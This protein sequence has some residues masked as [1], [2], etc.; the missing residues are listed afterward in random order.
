MIRRARWRAVSWPTCFSA[1][2]HL[3][4][5]PDCDIEGVDSREAKLLALPIDPFEHPATRRSSTHPDGL[6]PRAESPARRAI[7]RRLVRGQ[8]RPHAQ[9]LLT[10]LAVRRVRAHHTRPEARSSAPATHTQAHVCTVRARISQVTTRSPS[11]P[12]RSSPTSDGPR[13]MSPERPAA[14]APRPQAH[15]LRPE[16]DSVAR[17]RGNHESV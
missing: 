15:G 10:F 5:L 14:C 12:S 9:W 1:A 4:G 13:S 16:I 7:C 17:T 11:A 8:R 2:G 3:A 6:P